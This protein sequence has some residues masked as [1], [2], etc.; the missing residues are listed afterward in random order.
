VAFF[1]GLLVGLGA[2]A[3]KGCVVGNI[4]SGIGLLS[5]GTAIFAV[6]TF[7]GNQAATWFYLMGGGF[8]SRR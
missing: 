7:L 6:T 8:R 2:G 5:V 3:A 4:I 1:G